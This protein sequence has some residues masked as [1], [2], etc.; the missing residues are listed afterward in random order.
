MSYILK[1]TSGIITTRITDVGRRKLSQG[2]FNISYFQVG[3]SEVDYDLPSTYAQV[4]NNILMPAFNSQNNVGSPESNKQYVKY[5]YYVAGGTGSTYG[6]PYEDS[7]VQEIYNSAGTKGFFT[8]ETG[9]WVVQTSSAYTKTSNYYVDMSTLTGQKDITIVWDFCSTVTGYP[10][11]NDFITIYFDGNGTCDEVSPVPILTYRIQAI[12]PDPGTPS[13]SSYDITLDRAVPDYST[14]ATGGQIARVQIYPSGMTQLYDSITPAPYWIDD[15]IGLQSPC[16]LTTQ[17]SPIWNM[18]V[19]WTENP[20][21]LMSSLY[22]DYS[23]YDSITYAG[24]KEYLGYTSDSGQTDTS[25]TFYYNSFDEKSLRLIL[26]YPFTI[27][28]F[29]Y[30][31]VFIKYSCPICPNLCNSSPSKFEF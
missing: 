2:N 27:S 5:P 24:T 11:V 16:D 28:Y 25:K 30:L 31:H 29:I 1:N 12:S 4:N 18:N 26:L 9:T 8:G 19:P 22:E 23:Y 20:A 13:T 14:K 17:T 3:D 7:G 21:G 6:I 15:I 10:Q